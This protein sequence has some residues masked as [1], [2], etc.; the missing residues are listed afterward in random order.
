MEKEEVFQDEF[1]N[2]FSKF[3][4]VPIAVY[5]TG[6]RSGERMERGERD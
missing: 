6:I 1:D 3:K 2:Y 5:G 4:N